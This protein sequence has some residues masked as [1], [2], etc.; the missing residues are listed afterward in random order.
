MG[1]KVCLGIHTTDFGLSANVV[2][3]V[4]TPVCILGVAV[5]VYWLGIERSSGNLEDEDV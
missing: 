5:N 3:L 4:I 2:S 1:Q